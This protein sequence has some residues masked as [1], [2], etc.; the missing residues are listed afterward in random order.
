MAKKRTRPPKKYHG[1]S[2][3]DHAIVRY[4]ERVAGMDV[5]KMKEQIAKSV[6]PSVKALGDGRYPCCEGI[7]AVVDNNVVVT[8]V[9]CKKE[10]KG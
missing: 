7:R 2:V 9:E 3:S 10:R 6:S 5:E 8:M 4:M 1:I